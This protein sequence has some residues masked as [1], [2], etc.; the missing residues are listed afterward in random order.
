MDKSINFH[1]K[2]CGSNDPKRP[3]FRTNHK[4]KNPLQSSINASNNGG[5][6]YLLIFNANKLK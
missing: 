2:F 4:L 5:A 3:V 1:S 6:R